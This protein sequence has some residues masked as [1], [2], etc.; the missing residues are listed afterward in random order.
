[1]KPARNGR[2]AGLAVRDASGAAVVAVHEHWAAFAA[3]TPD[4]AKRL[5]QDGR[6]DDG[7][8][9]LTSVL[10]ALGAEYPEGP[11]TVPCDPD[12]G[13]LARGREQRAARTSAAEA[14]LARCV[15]TLESLKGKSGARRARERVVEARAALRKTK[16]PNAMERA[17]VVGNA[18]FDLE[19]VRDALRSLGVRTGALR[20]AGENEP[21]L[22][23]TDRGIAVVMPFWL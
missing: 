22:L 21:G 10:H 12:P 6:P 16:Q 11:V 2:F 13:L 8:P 23:L 7:L 17:V 14:E 3:A 15:A 1:M 5:V 19:L 18:M 20:A 4:E 9:S